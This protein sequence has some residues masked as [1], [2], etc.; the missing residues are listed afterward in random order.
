MKNGLPETLQ[1]AITYFAWPE[2]CQE[3]AAKLRWPDGPT[4]PRCESKEHSYLASRRIYKCKSCQKQYSVKVGTIFEDSPIGLDKW[5]VAIWMLANCKNG[6]SSYELH[7]AIGVTQKTAWFMLHRIRLAMKAQS[8]DKNL[9]GIVEADE[10]FIGGKLKNMHKSKRERKGYQKREGKQNAGSLVGKT[11]VQ[12]VI[13][14]DGE[15]RAQI[16]NSL[17]SRISG[18]C[19]SGR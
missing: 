2:T 5:L 9:C 12:G 11:I 3:F 10:T 8:F 18:R 14:R 6:V 15:V 19:S 4:C 13:E 17:E 16:L 1:E 7:R